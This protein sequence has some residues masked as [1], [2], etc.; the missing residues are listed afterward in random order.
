MAVSLANIISAV[1]FVL[2]LIGACW[3]MSS[4][5]TKNTDAVIALTARIDRMDADNTK[6]H[7]EMWDRIEKHDDA[8]SDHEARLQVLEHE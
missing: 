8:L 6:E 5:I 3:K 4:V 2:T 7:N 1:A